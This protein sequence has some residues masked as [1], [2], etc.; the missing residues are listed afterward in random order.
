[1]ANTV[2]D[3]EGA[4]KIVTVGTITYILYPDYG[5]TDPTAEGWGVKRID[6]TTAGTVKI[7]WANGSRAKT[8]KVN[9][10]SS[11]TFSNIV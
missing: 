5:V 9:N 11:L 8:N 6:S 1:M 4:Q 2:R 3:G 7:E 10:L